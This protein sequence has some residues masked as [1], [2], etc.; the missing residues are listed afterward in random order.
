MY[1][2]LENCSSQS[3]KETKD[4]LGTT[5][6]DKAKKLHLLGTLYNTAAMLQQGHPL[7]SIY[8]QGKV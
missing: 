3:V 6:V 5:E 8:L 1:T 4:P 7:N 2:V